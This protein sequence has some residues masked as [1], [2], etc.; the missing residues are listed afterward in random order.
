MALSCVRLAGRRILPDLS[1]GGAGRGGAS[2]E[3]TVF[4]WAE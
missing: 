4:F 1:S 2:R 3:G